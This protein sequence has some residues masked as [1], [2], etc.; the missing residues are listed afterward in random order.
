MNPALEQAL[1]KHLDALEERGLSKGDERSIRA[2]VPPTGGRGHRY[3]LQGSERAF[4]KM[5]SNDYLGFA[6][7]PELVR[8]AEVASKTYGV[9]PGAVRF[10][11]GTQDVHEELERRLADFHR[12][13]DSIVFNSAYA[14]V[15]STLSALITP[16]TAVLSDALNHNCIISGVRLA[17]PRHKAVYRHLDME[18]LSAKLEAVPAECNRL[19]LVTDGVF[20]MRGTHAPLRQLGERLGA[21][22]PRFLEGAVLVIDDS[23]GV[24]AFG[25]T[26][27]GTEEVTRARADVLVGTLGKAFGVNGGYVTGTGVLTRFLRETSPMYI[28]SNPIG[29]AEAAAL[30]R[31]LELVQAAEGRARLNN[32]RARTRQF[33]DGLR[34]L[35]AEILE[36]DHPVTPLMVRDTERTRRLV[37]RLYEG[38]VLATGLTYPVVP[39]GDE[40]IRFQINANLTE[41][42]ID[43]VLSVASKALESGRVLR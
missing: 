31:A 11:S 40:S 17:R 18:D 32:L 7:H 22:A 38:G 6:T 14:A 9:G 3:L 10:I 42:D 20:S 41:G 2:V 43:E 4:I 8:A 16:N 33:E 1:R 24:G 34:A 25:A 21:H 36:G 35:G 28:Y 30:I 23:H 19:L 12:R 13:E 39:E 37:E 27:R 29:P 26:G 15:V 5:N